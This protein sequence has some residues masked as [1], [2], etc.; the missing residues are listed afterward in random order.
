MTKMP[1]LD[2]QET[3]VRIMDFAVG[4][5]DAE[6]KELIQRLY[7]EQCNN[8]APLYELMFICGQIQRWCMELFD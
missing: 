5:Y 7:E 8:G 1:D 2:I 6:A 3:M 4:N